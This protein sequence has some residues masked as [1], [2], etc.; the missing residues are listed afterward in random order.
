MSEMRKLVFFMETGQCGTGAVEFIEVPHTYTDDQLADLAW[1]LARENAEM[2][3]I[4]PEQDYEECTSEEIDE[5]GDSL[6]DNIEGWWEEYN[7]D[8]HDGLVVG[9]GEPQWSQT[10]VY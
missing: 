9:C 6:S 8:E 2:Y 3:G 1:T 5:L 4:Y 7:P 10:A